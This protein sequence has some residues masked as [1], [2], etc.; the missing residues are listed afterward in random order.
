MPMTLE[1]LEQEAMHL[2][3]LARARLAEALTASLEDAPDARIQQLWLT[4]ARRR[5]EEV[6]SGRVEAIAGEAVLE[7][8]R[9]LVTQ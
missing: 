7:E 5:H 4:E 6:R 8:V 3:G 9:R 1:Q 2:P